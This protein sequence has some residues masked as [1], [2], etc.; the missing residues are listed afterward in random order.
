MI[1]YQ[2]IVGT[3]ISVTG[4]TVSIQLSDTVK[5][6]S[7]IIDGVVY[8]IGQIGSFLKI[9]LGYCNLYGIVTQIGASA[10]PINLLDKYI[11]NGFE[12]L[13]NQQW[14]TMSLIGEQIGIRFERGVSQSPTT[15]DA[16]HLVTISDLKNIY[17]DY[18]QVSSINVGNIS[19]S[20][21]LNAFLDL[22]KLVSRHFAILGS[23]GSGKSNA[24][25]VTINSIIEK[26][27]KRSRII[28]LDPHG[29]YNTVFKSHST[30]FKVGNKKEESLYVPYWA[31]PFNEL[32]SLFEAPISDL[33]RDYFRSK[34]V[35]YKIQGAAT[36]GISID[37][38]LI[39]ADSPIPF[40]LKQ[41]WFDLDDFERQTYNERGKPETKT[42]L[43]VKGNADKLISNQYEPASTNNS[44]PFLNNLAKGIL[45]F[46]DAIRLKLKDTRY[47]FLFNPGCYA[48]D[49]SGKVDKDIN[50]LLE[51]WLGTNKSIAIFD[52]S[53][54]PSEL[55][56]SISGT[57]LNIVYDA[58]FWGQNL[59]NGGKRQPLLIV[60]EEA[61]NYLHAREN[62][63]ASRT[64]QRIAKEGRKY[65]VGLLL[66]TQR[67]SELDETVLSQCGTIIALRMNNNKDRGFVSAAIQ[68]ELK[69]LVELLPSL[70]TGEAIVSGEGVKIPSRIQFYKLSNA[71]KGAE[72]SVSK[73]WSD[74]VVDNENAYKDLVTLWRNK[75]FEL[76]N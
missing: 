68:D 73:Q 21:S 47:N 61:H 46:L 66:V 1:N 67:P 52:L 12:S 24:V 17:S 56:L 38:T 3:V 71:F 11:E 35:E 13:A 64:V 22:D 32:M 65:G 59:S 57:L 75:K 54:V 2:T 70:R 5:S 34:I 53:D 31:L 27:F 18:N 72:P 48:P 76:E 30:V 50:C 55:M 10:I 7:P 28:I 39:T 23:T 36:N 40:S 4:N 6:N 44:K 8:R 25:G 33:N 74:S 69:S 9:P 15:G 60:L 16:V 58:L 41:L 20:E 62:S 63:I 37:S 45:S 43:I 26:N 49:L 19:V 29:E 42:K 51:S 14:L